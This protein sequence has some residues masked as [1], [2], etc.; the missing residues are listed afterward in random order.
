M[1]HPGTWLGVCRSLAC[2]PP[3]FQ[4]LL[5]GTQYHYAGF[6][7]KLLASVQCPPGGKARPQA[8]CSCSFFH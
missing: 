1:A 2:G 5:E 3:F 8:P 6:P 7:Q 4:I